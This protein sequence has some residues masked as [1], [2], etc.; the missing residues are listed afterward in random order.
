MAVGVLTY[1]HSLFVGV[2]YMR[3]LPATSILKLF[4]TGPPQ[5]TDLSVAL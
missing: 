4:K 3:E 1:R 2:F 5:R